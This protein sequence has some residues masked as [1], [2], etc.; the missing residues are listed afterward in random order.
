MR[1]QRELLIGRVLRAGRHST[2]HDSCFQTESFTT[3]CFIINCYQVGR[4]LVLTASHLNFSNGANQKADGEWPYSRPRS[5]N[6][7]QDTSIDIEG[8]IVLALPSPRRAQLRTLDSP[9]HH[10][11]GFYGR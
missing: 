2:T 6:R 11:L 7:T 1:F 9:L 10:Y 5:H 4:N 8:T 3:T